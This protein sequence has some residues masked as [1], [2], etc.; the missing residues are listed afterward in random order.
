MNI[1]VYSHYFHP[2]IGAPS[3]RIYDLSRQW[4]NNGNSVQVITCFPNHPG[5]RLYT[6]YTKARYMYESIDG[7]DVHRHW[8]Y[9][10]RNEGVMK[11]TLGH[12]SFLP[13]AL[14]IS[15]RKIQNPDVVVGTSPTLFA[16]QAASSTGG[17]RRVPFVMEI[18]DLWPAIFVELGVLK[19]K[20][21]IR[22]LERWEMNLYGKATT[23]VTVTEAFRQNLIERGISSEKVITIPNGA[24]VEFWS[25]SEAMSDLRDKLNLDGKF[26]VLYIGAHGI[27]HAL[28]K[29]ID[30]AEI[31]KTE[32]NIS[33]LFVGEGAEKRHLI[34][35]A[36]TKGLNNIQFLDPVKKNEVKEYY[37]LAD[38]CLVPLRDIPLFDNFIPSKMFEIMAMEK[39]IIGSVR[40]ESAD[41]LKKSEGALVV[42]PENSIQISDAIDTLYKN[43][44]MGPEM[45]KK[46]REFVKRYYSRAVLSKKYLKVLSDSIHNYID[47]S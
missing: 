22:T 23:I 5:G 34:E 15:N 8:T 40:G 12:L 18:R 36:Q 33:F 46:G 47:N 17:R 14:Y 31:L 4:I 27:S 42:E 2:E 7:I 13:F 38:V 43:P 21:L 41:I 44:L 10:T 25:P 16:A 6:G 19:N 28:I 20:K 35:Y 26:V 30:C 9:I 24:D 32:K 39:P 45:G 1:A 3:A 11:R 29:I 37:E